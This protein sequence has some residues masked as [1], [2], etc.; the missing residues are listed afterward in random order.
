[1]DGT[2]RRDHHR[3][4]RHRA[5]QGGR[6]RGGRCEGRPDAHRGGRARRGGPSVTPRDS[7]E[8]GGQPDV[9]PSVDVHLPPTTPTP[10]PP[11]EPDG[12]PAPVEPTPVEPPPPEANA[13]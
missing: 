11:S 7:G 5:G 9:P 10:P 8:G 13:P 3:L 6:V 2:R 4:L 12:P 1:A